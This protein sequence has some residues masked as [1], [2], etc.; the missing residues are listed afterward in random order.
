MHFISQKLISL[1]PIDQA[2]FGFSGTY[3]AA[4]TGSGLLSFRVMFPNRLVDWDYYGAA[5]VDKPNGSEEGYVAGGC[6]GVGACEAGCCMKV[7][8][9]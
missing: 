8:A 7:K 3:Y 9:F 6:T 2:S 5:G 4:Y 1:A